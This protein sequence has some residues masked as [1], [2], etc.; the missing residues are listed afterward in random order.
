MSKVVCVSGFFDPL[1]FGHIDYLK[2]AKELAG[3]SG[4]L[5]VIVNNDKQ[6]EMKKGA[7]FMPCAERVKMVRSL[8]VVDVAMEAPDTDHTVCKGIAAVIPDVFAI[9]LD[10]GPEYMK[11]GDAFFCV[12]MR[13]YL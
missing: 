1:H 13:V 7:S 9:G 3:P 11:V 12:H 8:G 5:F 6:A 10:E 4:T 2:K